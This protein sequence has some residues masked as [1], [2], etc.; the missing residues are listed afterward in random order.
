MYLTQIEVDE[1]KLW[2]GARVKNHRTG[3]E[4]EIFVVPKDKTISQCVLEGLFDVAKNVDYSTVMLNSHLF[5]LL[6]DD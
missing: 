4:F 1:E 5:E 2:N 6:N 3:R